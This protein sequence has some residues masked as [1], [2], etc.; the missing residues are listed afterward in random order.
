MVPKLDLIP[1]RIH[2]GSS[3]IALALFAAAS[4]ICAALALPVPWTGAW[5]S[6]TDWL[7]LAFF[8]VA[9]AA[10]GAAW[11]TAWWWHW[12]G[13]GQRVRLGPF[14]RFFRRG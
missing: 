13:R 10:S 4:S 14:M 2:D 8:L 7:R 6:W 5:G 11:V 1:D 9:L 3:R 12:L